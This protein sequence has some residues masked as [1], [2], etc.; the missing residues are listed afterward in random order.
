VPGFRRSGEDRYR[1]RIDPRKSRW[2]GRRR[3]NS[4]EPAELAARPRQ[5]MLK[6]NAGQEYDK[7]DK[8][9]LGHERDH[10]RISEQAGKIGRLTAARPGRLLRFGDC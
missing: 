2:D 10:I 7:N 1:A 6:E 4:P 8:E 9:N 5:I 3:V